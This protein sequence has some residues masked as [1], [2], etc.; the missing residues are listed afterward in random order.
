MSALE[1]TVP[2]LSSLISTHSQLESHQVVVVARCGV[3]DHAHGL[4]ARHC[5]MV[6]VLAIELLAPVIRL[7]GRVQTIE[8]GPVLPHLA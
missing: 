8:L 5:S 4:L 7:E 6:A 2:C 1:T 3:L